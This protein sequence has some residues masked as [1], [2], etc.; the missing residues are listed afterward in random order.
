V[1]SSPASGTPVREWDSEAGIFGWDIPS[2]SLFQPWRLQNQFYDAETEAVAIVAGVK[3]VLRPGI[4]TNHHRAYDSLTGSFLQVDPLV[5]QTQAAYAY[6]DQDPVNHADPSGLTVGGPNDPWW[7]MCPLNSTPDYYDPSTN[8]YWCTCNFGFEAQNGECVSSP[9]GWW[10]NNDVS[11][12]SPDPAPGGGGRG[13]QG[14]APDF[15]DAGDEYWEMVVMCEHDPSIPH[16]DELRRYQVD[17]NGKCMWAQGM[18]TVGGAVGGTPITA[19]GG[20]AVATLTS[21][22][23]DR[24]TEFGHTY[25]FG[26]PGIVLDAL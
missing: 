21:D 10:F 8:T 5:L 23:C 24:G 3:K 11:F 16:C 2:T 1:W 15:D 13:P 18:G 17:Q 14:P 26:W 12:P 19:I 4:A 25:I 9:A 6:A 20:F 22:A 7:S